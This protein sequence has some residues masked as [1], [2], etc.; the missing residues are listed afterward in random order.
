MRLMIE[1]RSAERDNDT[2][3]EGDGVLA[4]IEGLC[5]DKKG[6]VEPVGIYKDCLHSNRIELLSRISGDAKLS[7]WEQQ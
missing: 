4:V 3:E 2:V 1:A 5:R 7:R 6:H